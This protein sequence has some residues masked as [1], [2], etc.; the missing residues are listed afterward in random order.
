M[1]NFKM[2]IL[3]SYKD[4]WFYILLKCVH[5][6]H[7]LFPGRTADIQRCIMNDIIARLFYRSCH[8]DNDP[9]LYTFVRYQPSMKVS[10]GAKIRNRYNQIPHLTQDTNGKVTNS[11]LD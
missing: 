3:F 9:Y 2:S 1:A 7:H 10:K 8:L 11:Q 4:Q 5:F 6:V